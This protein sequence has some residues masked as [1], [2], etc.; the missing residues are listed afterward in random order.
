MVDFPTGLPGQEGQRAANG[1]STVIHGR[2]DKH[3]VYSVQ[4]VNPLVELH[5]GEDAAGD[6]QVSQSRTSHPVVHELNTDFFQHQL[7]AGGQ[8]GDIK[9]VRQLFPNQP[10]GRAVI[11]RNSVANLTRLRVANAPAELLGVDGL[12][13]GR[14]SGDLAFV[15]FR[16]ESA[17]LRHVGIEVAQRI[18]AVYAGYLGQTT[19]TPNINTPRLPVSTSIQR[20]DERLVKAAGEVGRRGVAMVIVVETDRG[21]DTKVLT[22]HSGYLVQSFARQQALDAMMR[23]PGQGKATQQRSQL[24]AELI[25]VVGLQRFVTGEPAFPGNWLRFEYADTLCYRDLIDVGRRD[26]GQLNDLFD[27]LPGHAAGQFHPAQTLFGNGRD[28]AAVDQDC[29]RGRFTV[30]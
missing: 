22:Q 18:E 23:P 8:V 12:S 3:A 13:G 21:G 25:E 20:D 26:A 17:Q 4:F 29:G 10:Q 27:G 28:N 19:M 9:L 15:F 2:V 16:P 24:A 7:N 1:K 30:D 11:H 5:V 6:G 14:Q